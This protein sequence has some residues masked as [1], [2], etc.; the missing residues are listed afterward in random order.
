MFPSMDVYV[1]HVHFLAM[2]T[3]TSIKMSVPLGL[4]VDTSNPS[5]RDVE[6]SL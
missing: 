5:T 1:A 2:K 4:V 6:T 3:N